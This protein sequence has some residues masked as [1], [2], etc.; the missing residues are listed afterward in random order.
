MACQN[1][2]IRAGLLVSGLALSVVAGVGTAGAQ[3]IQ[4]LYVGAGA[5]VNF[6]ERQSLPPSPGLG[7]P[8]LLANY[9]AGFAGAGSLGYA[10]GNGWRFEVEGNYRSNAV[11]RL[12]GTSFPTSAGGTQQDYGVMTNALFDIDIGLPWLF[13]YVGGGVGYGW[14]RWS[15][16]HASPPGGA[17]VLEASGTTGGFAFQAIG[18]LAFPIP[19]TPGLSV[20]AEY[21][22]MGVLGPEAFQGSSAAPGSGNLDAKENHNHSLLVGLR[23]AFNVV[24]P[25]PPAPVVPVAPAVQ[26]RSYLVFFDWDKAALTDRARQIIA[27]AAANMMK[28]PHTRIE[29]KGYTDTSGSAAYNQALSL[30]RAKAVGAELVR[31]GI[32]GDQIG[33]QGFGQTVLLV[34]TG[35]GVREAQNRR[36]E[37]IATP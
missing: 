23:Y 36:V 4:G 34:Q 13:P 25:S 31:L 11:N 3:P 24:P 10:L 26:T 12:T 19:H 20:T 28:V 1:R 18:G 33:I 15:G 16:V 7:T 9:G 6:L 8:G 35:P 22:F 32:P 30:R 17:A 5:G 14:T 21:R 37:I 2:I 27:D 29:V